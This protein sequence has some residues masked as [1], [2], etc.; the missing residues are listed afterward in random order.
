MVKN[1]PEK[2]QKR[3]KALK[4]IQLEYLKL[5]TKFYEEVYQI[6]RKYQDLYQPLND[7]RK[8]IITGD[9]EPSDAESQYK[10][11]TE[12]EEED[13]EMAKKLQLNSMKSLP[14]YDENVKGIP[15]FW[16][17]LMVSWFSLYSR[18]GD[19]SKIS[20]RQMLVK[21]CVIFAWI[22]CCV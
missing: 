19:C 18:F 17:T 21:R 15:D 14:K 2:A 9:Y 22:L 4:N 3:V 13:D 1:L 6:E 11:D 5:E 8:T 20:E 16:L 7:K 12:G 10:S